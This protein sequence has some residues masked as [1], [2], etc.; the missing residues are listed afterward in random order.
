MSLGYFEELLR[1]LTDEEREAVTQFIAEND[2]F[3]VHS[4]LSRRLTGAAG[5]QAYKTSTPSS[6]SSKPETG[7]SYAKRGLPWVMALARIE[8]A[9]I[10]AAFT[11]S[12][13]PFVNV[14]PTSVELPAYKELLAD[15]I[16][17]HYFSLHRDPALRRVVNISPDNPVVLSYSRRLGLA[18]KMLTAVAKAG[19]GELNP[20]QYRELASW[21]RDLDGLHAGLLHNI[22]SYLQTVQERSLEQVENQSTRDF[23]RACGMQLQGEYREKRAGTARIY[24]YNTEE[25]RSAN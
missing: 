21:K 4:N 14:R 12:A 8:Y 24:R 17:M 11:T 23:V 16:R 6:S 9:S 10:L 13:D 15:G 22:Q 7:N 2:A 25:S 3:T 19:M 5:M 20:Y 18:R 1:R